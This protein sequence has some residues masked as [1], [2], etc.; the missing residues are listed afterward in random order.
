MKT[1]TVC[2][3]SSCFSRG[4]SKN[5]QIIQNFIEEYNL[6]DSVQVRGCLCEG[7]C[8]H[9]PNIRIDDKLFPNVYSEGLIDLLQ[10]E[11]L[12]ENPQ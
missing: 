8:K 4:N 6:S 12:Q 3:G 11:L 5:T 9:G 2:M 1:I 10:H 7:E